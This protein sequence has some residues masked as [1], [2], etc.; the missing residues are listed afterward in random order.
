V[1]YHLNHTSSPFFSGYFG[2]RVSLFAHMGLD[3]NLP[4][5]ILPAIIGMTGKCQLFFS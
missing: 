4:I 1:L 5:L 2:D 3:G